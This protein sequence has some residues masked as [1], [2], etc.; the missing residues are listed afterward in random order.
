[1][2]E[3][4]HTFV[5]HPGNVKSR[6]DGQW[7]W[8]SAADLRHLY[9]V[10]GDAETLVVDWRHP[11]RVQQVMAGRQE[12]EERYIHLYPNHAGNYRPV[13]NIPYRKR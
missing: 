2:A 7:H 10:P 13:T 5:L 4:E 1:M 3:V 12:D 6:H 11:D 8:I 9:K